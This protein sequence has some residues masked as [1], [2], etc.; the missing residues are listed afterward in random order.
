MFCNQ[1]L[2]YMTYEKR[3]KPR[4][5]NRATQKVFTL[6]NAILKVIGKL[7]HLFLFLSLSLYLSF[8]QFVNQTDKNRSNSN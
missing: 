8:C 5:N 3:N 1:T 6:K 4:Q 7:N 2:Y